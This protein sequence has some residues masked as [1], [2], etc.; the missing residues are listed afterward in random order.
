MSNHQ[1][2]PIDFDAL[3]RLTGQ[4][5]ELANELLTM[6]AQE[7]PEMR[8]SI[9]QHLSNK[10]YAELQSAIHKLHGSCCYCAATALQ[11]LAKTTETE[12]KENSLN[13]IP[14]LISRIEQEIMCV[15]NYISQN[16]IS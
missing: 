3:L 13:D 10:Q 14:S 2:A 6:F 16:R 11:M 5:R 4:N 15:L 12:L 1:T 7:L 8:Q 9:N